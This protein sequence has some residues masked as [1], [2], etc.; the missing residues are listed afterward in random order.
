MK[1]RLVCFAMILILSVPMTFGQKDDKGKTSFGVIGGVNLQNLTGKD[2]SGDKLVNNMILGFH[3]GLNIQ[4]P[5]ADPIYIQPGLIFST[6][7][8]KSINGSLASTYNI[9]YIEMPLN[10]V[11]KGRLGN[12]YVLLGFGPYVAYAVGGKVIS[13]LGDVTVKTDIEFQNTVELTDPLL[14]TYLKAFDAGGNI[15]A[16]FEMSG[17]LFILLN[18]QLGMLKINPEN[19]WLSSDK[20]SVKNTGFGLSLGYRF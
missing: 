20:S 9:S 10:L 8:A 7:G 5:L 2:I 3:A 17:G 14:T 4:I 13:E 18:A 12:S 11:Y 19:K 15:F 16:G 1:T 6:K